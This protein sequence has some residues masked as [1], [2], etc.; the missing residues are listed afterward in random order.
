MASLQKP[1]P[2]WAQ[3]TYTSAD[4]ATGAKGG[5]G[6]KERSAITTDL[7]V[8]EI[9]KGVSTR[10]VEV[11][12]TSNF[13]S[14]EE[15]RTRPRRLLFRLV[16]GVPTMWHAA[17]AGPDATGRPGNV[18]T[19]A[20]MLAS[21][22]ATLRPIEYWRSASWLTPF[23][24]AAVTAAKLGDL[25]PGSVITRRSTLAFI[26][27][28]EREYAVEWL[29]AAVTYAVNRRQTWCSLPARPTRRQAGL[30]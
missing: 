21:P 6:I 4:S 9:L 17:T 13:P 11:S 2:T 12:P 5:W 18:Y 1:P 27:H 24:A 10:I 29:L 16:N 8:S 19:H 7:M 23:G 14:D 15:L 22:D 26:D 3:L 30:A 25:R 20:A 28:G